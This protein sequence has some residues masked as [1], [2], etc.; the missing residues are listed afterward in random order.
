MMTFRS[1]WIRWMP[2]QPSFGA[3]K[4]LRMFQDV[5]GKVAVLE[6]ASC[7]KHAHPVA[8]LGEPQSANG[9]PEARADDQ[10]V[11]VMRGSGAVNRRPSRLLR[12]PMP[13]CPDPDRLSP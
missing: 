11:I 10:H 3:H 1:M 4:N 9:A 5:P 2:W 7:L 13:R 12:P 8:L 6:P